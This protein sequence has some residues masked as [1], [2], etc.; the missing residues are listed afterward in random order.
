MKLLAIW[1][2]ASYVGMHSKLIRNETGLDIIGLADNIC[3]I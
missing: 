2:A 1:K 3:N